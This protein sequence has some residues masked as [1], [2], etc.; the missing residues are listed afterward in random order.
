MKFILNILLPQFELVYAHTTE[1]CNNTR[2][3][4]H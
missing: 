2:T 1:M 3:L 4:S